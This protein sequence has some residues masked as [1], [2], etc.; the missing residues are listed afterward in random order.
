M[1]L[2][3]QMDINQKREQNLEELINLFLSRKRKS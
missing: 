2:Q 1:Y 3:K